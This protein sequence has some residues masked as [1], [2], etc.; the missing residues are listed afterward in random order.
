MCTHLRALSKSY[1]MNTNMAGD[2]WFSKIFVLVLW[3]KT[4]LCLSEKNTN[5]TS[6]WP[7]CVS[8]EID[9]AVHVK[10]N[11]KCHL[12]LFDH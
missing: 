2:R 5:H 6:K 4:L 12:D 9:T 8:K 7:K 1:P 11:T 10:I 3:T